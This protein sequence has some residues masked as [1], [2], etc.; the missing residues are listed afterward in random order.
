MARMSKYELREA[1]PGG[2]R[3]NS[4]QNLWQWTKASNAPDNE[5]RQRKHAAP[6]AVLARRAALFRHRAFAL[7][8]SVRIQGDPDADEVLGPSC[9][10]D[11]F[12]V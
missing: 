12:G 5:T 3:F 4:L 6:A 2:L 11:C 10:Q 9:V 1:A 8:I 7:I